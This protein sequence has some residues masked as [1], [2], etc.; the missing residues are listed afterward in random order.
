MKSILFAIF[1]SVTSIMCCTIYVRESK[2][3]RPEIKLNTIS[4]NL[5][6][7][8]KAVSNPVVNNV[9]QKNNLIKNYYCDDLE[10]RI[11][12]NG[13]RFRLSG[14]LAYEKPNN[15]RLEISSI[16]G[17]ELDLGSNEKQFWYWSR[18]D[19]N[20]AL[21]WAVYED[22]NKTRLKT[23]FNPMFMRS[24]LGLESLSLTD[25]KITEN[26]KNL[27]VTYPRLDSMGVRILYS[28]F[29]NK[30]RKQIEGFLITSLDGRNLV[31]CEIQEWFV[32]KPSKINYVWHEEN[33]TMSIY[34]N[35]P[36]TNFLIS[37]ENFLFPNYSP[38]INM[39]DE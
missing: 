26:E 20:P 24:T 39:A 33:R 5:E 22:F 6:T 36:K 37:K 21:Y 27:M 14:K 19:R 11:W 38:K 28:V 25:A 16:F 15:F 34:L 32:D 10:V 13:H 4:R 35:N 18:R 8:K 23:P 29:I 17:T 12:E 7:P 2:I 30:E 1:I 31:E 9:N 3:N